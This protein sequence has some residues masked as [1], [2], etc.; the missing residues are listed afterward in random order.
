[1]L[2]SPTAAAVSNPWERG[3]RLLLA[4]LQ[5]ENRAWLVAGWSALLAL[6]AILLFGPALSP[7]AGPSAGDADSQLGELSAREKQLV[8]EPTDIEQKRIA[9]FA[10]LRDPQPPQPPPPQTAPALPPGQLFGVT[11]DH[12]QNFDKLTHDLRSAAAECADWIGGGGT[13]GTAP[14]AAGAAQEALSAAASEATKDRAVF[15]YHQGLIDL[16]GPNGPSAVTEFKAAQKSY[17]A[18]LKE[19]GGREKLPTADSRR[20]A[21]YET[22]TSYGLGLAQLELEAGKSPNAADA[23]F[24]AALTSAGLIRAYSPPGPFVQLSRN[25]C[26]GAG[27]DCDLFQ[28]NTADIYNARL[29][30]WLTAGKP[31]QAYAGVKAAL[32]GTPTYVAQHPKLAANFALAAATAGDFASVRRLY[33]VVR[34]GLE[35]GGPEEEAW[36]ADPEALARLVSIAAMAQ[37]PVYADGDTWWPVA[38]SASGTRTRFEASV[39]SRD[40]DWFPAIAL[41]DPGDEASLDLWLWLR[42]DRSLLQKG[43]FSLFRQDGATIGSLGPGDRDFLERWRRAVT[44]RLGEALLQRAEV[45]RRQEGLRKAAPMLQLMSGGDFPFAIRAQARLSLAR[46]APPQDIVV[47]GGITLL[48]AL[49]A[50]LAHLDLNIGYSRTFTRRHFRHRT[51]AEAGVGLR[52]GPANAP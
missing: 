14:A 27:G 47:G 46:D 19:H 52:R 40:A 43:A 9:E 5:A 11:G 4:S 26:S 17:A 28:F 6:L 22:V 15:H 23:T 16:C 51:R 2:T 33:G 10:M 20:L 1:M 42:R 8:A 3:R 45:V 50:G 25:G 7:F 37:A 32:A 35:G 18:Y 30:A 24:Q 36:R 12:A 13:T 31:Q 39:A 48:V 21:Q 34:A 41:R 49:L 38:P 44:G 29:Y